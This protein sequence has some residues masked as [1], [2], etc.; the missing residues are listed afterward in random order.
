MGPPE[1]DR[2]RKDQPMTTVTKVRK[3]RSPSGTHDHIEGVCTSTGVHYSR[4]QVVAGLDRG[5]DWHTSAGGST[6]KIRKIAKCAHPGC[7]LTPYIS[8]APDHTASN[9]LDNLPIC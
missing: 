8:T 2:L 3:D 5:E 4:A 7:S 9:N 1:H 6:A